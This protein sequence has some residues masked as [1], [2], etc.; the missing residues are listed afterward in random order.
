MRKYFLFGAVF[1]GS[2]FNLGGCAH[3]QSSAQLPPDNGDCSAYVD[4]G[5]PVA[6]ERDGDICYR[7]IDGKSIV[8]LTSKRGSVII[9]EKIDSASHVVIKAN[10]DVRVGEKIDGASSVRLE[11]GHD[12]IVGGKID[13]GS[14][15]TVLAGN[16]VVIQGVIKGKNDD[17]ASQLY[18]KSSDSVAI[19]DE[20]KN[21][22]KLCLHAHNGARIRGPV[23]DQATM[24]SCW[25]QRCDIAQSVQ[26]GA[27]IFQNDC[28][29]P[30]YGAER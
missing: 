25:P 19:N 24:I 28:R 9:K 5:S 11:A 8:S 23:D 10:Y 2:I 7:Y 17:V 30:T 22:V 21:G 14:S 13:G 18:V 1:L 4:G 12:V 16:A 29:L 6:I 27:R 3:S 26:N 20:V 15:V